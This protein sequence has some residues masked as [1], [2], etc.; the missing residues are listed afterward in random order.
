MYVAGMC[1]AFR[2]GAR[3]ASYGDSSSARDRVREVAVELNANPNN[4]WTWSLNRTAIR[5]SWCVG[6]VS[7]LCA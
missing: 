3:V 7:D 5:H 6:L 1:S 4:G 2:L